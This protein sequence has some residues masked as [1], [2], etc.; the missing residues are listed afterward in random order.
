MWLFIDGVLPP[1]TS[2]QVRPYNCHCTVPPHKSEDA[3]NTVTRV[4]DRSHLTHNKPY[5]TFAKPQYTCLHLYQ[6]LV[7]GWRGGRLRDHEEG[8][9][10]G[11]D[12]GSIGSRL[13]SGN[14]AGLG[15]A[16]RARG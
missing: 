1:C 10:V 9:V 8:R 3:K 5:D 2:P 7:W 16:A 15:L 13:G 4:H 11:G 12:L 6:Y 14:R